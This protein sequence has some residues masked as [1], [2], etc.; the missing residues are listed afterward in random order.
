MKTFADIL[1]LRADQA[2]DSIAYRFW[3]GTDSGV[4]QLTYG[5]LYARS[6]AMADHLRAVCEPGGRV[7]IMLPPGLS[8][9]VALFG[10]F[11][12]GVVAVP[13]YAATSR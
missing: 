9:L 3:G 5:E 8:Y 2:T 4:D 1:A 11:I 10:C 6:R 12:A 13:L 7:L